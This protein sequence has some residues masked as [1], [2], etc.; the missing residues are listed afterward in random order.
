ML[1]YIYIVV[2][3]NE[4]FT[5]MEYTFKSLVLVGDELETNI[6]IYIG[7]F[8]PISGKS[9]PELTYILE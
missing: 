6:L 7:N 1:I 3:I 5:D 2:I 8:H 4:L 9:T